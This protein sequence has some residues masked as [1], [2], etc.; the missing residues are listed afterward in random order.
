MLFYFPES[1]TKYF[2][3]IMKE[4]IDKQLPI[5]ADNESFGFLDLLKKKKIKDIECVLDVF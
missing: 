2:N 1:E 4:L 3:V 5:Q